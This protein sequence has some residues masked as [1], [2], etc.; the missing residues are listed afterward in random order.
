M[1]QKQRTNK[2]K[3]ARTRTVGKFD[4]VRPLPGQQFV[5]N[6]AVEQI[7]QAIVSGLHY[8]P[9]HASA[10]LA[11]QAAQEE[12]TSA[13]IAYYVPAFDEVRL[14]PVQV[15]ALV[16][17]GINYRTLLWYI[18]H[19]DTIGGTPCWMLGKPY[20]SRILGPDIQDLYVNIEAL[21]AAAYQFYNDEHA[22]LVKEATNAT[23]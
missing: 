9:S 14:H 13:R 1:Q 23:S 12:Q 3:T 7:V 10:P 21:Y 5:Q 4:H 20:Q 6:G 15:S 17:L 18:L 19:M 22:R 2:S 11:E 16:A 8:L